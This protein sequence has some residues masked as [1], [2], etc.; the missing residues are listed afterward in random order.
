M[1]ACTGLLLWRRM[2]KAAC[3]CCAGLDRA[4]AGLQLVVHCSDRQSR[5]SPAGAHQ[6]GVRQLQRHSGGQSAACRV[7]GWQ[8]SSNRNRHWT[9]LLPLAPPHCRGA[10]IPSA[11][12]HLIWP[13]SVPPLPPFLAQSLVCCIRPKASF[14]QL[15]S[16]HHDT[17]AAF[18]SSN[19]ACRVT[20][21][22][23][24]SHRVPS[25]VLFFSKAW[26][27]SR[28]LQ[29][30]AHP[31]ARHIRGLATSSALMRTVCS[32]SFRWSIG[33]ACTSYKAGRDR[34]TAGRPSSGAARV[35][36]LHVTAVLQLQVTLAPLQH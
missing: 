23:R 7:E 22:A 13:L 10:F 35:G 2:C 11:A 16:V 20:V 30:L 5:D 29:Y 27:W 12:R 17:Q 21:Q 15:L 1:R 33:N 26:L 32:A 19:A 18:K 36:S 4:T 9:T 14:G 6:R 31:Q 3:G 34:L 28:C 8:P 24:I 25:A